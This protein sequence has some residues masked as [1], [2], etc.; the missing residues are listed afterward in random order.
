[1]G[2]TNWKLITRKNGQKWPPLIPKNANCHFGAR[3]SN[4]HNSA[5]FH[6]IFTF[7]LLNCLF[8]RDESKLYLLCLI[9]RFLAPVLLR[10]LK[11]AILRTWTQN[12]PQ[13]VGTCLGL[14]LQLISQYRGFQNDRPDPSPP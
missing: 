7:L 1:M 14:P 11:W 9:F 8:F 10:G 2:K 5:I 3:L 4:W 6:S 12:H 13:K